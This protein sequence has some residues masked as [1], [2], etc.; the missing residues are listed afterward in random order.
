MRHDLL[1]PIPDEEWMP[2]S[3]YCMWCEVIGQARDSAVDD[4]RRRIR[5]GVEGLHSRPL[6]G[7]RVV[8]LNEVLD[9]IVVGDDEHRPG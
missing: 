2:E 3:V 7:R 6:S 9:V 8:S 1:C 5:G 4:E